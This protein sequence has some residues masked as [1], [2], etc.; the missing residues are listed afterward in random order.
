MGVN[1]GVGV[2]L[3]GVEQSIDSL[4]R[5]VLLTLAAHESPPSLKKNQLVAPSL[6]HVTSVVR[7]ESL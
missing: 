2:G 4:I 6:P 7:L 5:P 1:V 3:A